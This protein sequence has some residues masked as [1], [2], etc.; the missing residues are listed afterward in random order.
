MNFDFLSA[1]T[2]KIPLCLQ[3]AIEPWR[4]YLHGIFPPD[5][6]ILFDER[7]DLLVKMQAFFELD[8]AFFM[9]QQKHYGRRSVSILNRKLYDLQ[10]MCQKIL[11]DLFLYAFFDIIKHVR[12]AP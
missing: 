4:G 9:I 1:H 8:A 7:A 12:A 6:N 10:I 11:A 5:Q 2:H 3:W